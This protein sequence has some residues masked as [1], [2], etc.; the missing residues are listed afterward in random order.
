MNM[1][2]MHLEIGAVK[3]TENGFAA[4]GYIPEIRDPVKVSGTVEPDALGYA[5][6][7]VVHYR[8]DTNGRHYEYVLRYGYDTNAGLSFLPSSIESFWIN[9]TDQI[10]LADFALISIKASPV[11]LSPSL[12][13]PHKVLSS[14][15]MPVVF[16]R[17]GA[18]YMTNALGHL[19][20]IPTPLTGSRMLSARDGLARNQLYYAIVLLSTVAAFSTIRRINKQNKRQTLESILI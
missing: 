4:T 7:M 5:R 19:A 1:G 16:Y 12:F 13:N 17:K 18:W 2:V 9:G 8:T 10:K 15:A 20:P 11:A 6:E 14:N 3:W